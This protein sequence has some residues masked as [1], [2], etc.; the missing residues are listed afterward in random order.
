[1]DRR[2]PVGVLTL[3]IAI[4]CAGL[5]PA[6]ASAENISGTVTN[7][8]SV[9]IEG[10]CVF[11]QDANN[12]MS[13]Y[14]QTGTNASGQ[15]TV[16]VPGA[17]SYVIAFRT[18]TNGLCGTNAT[19]VVAE[20]WN[21]DVYFTDADPIAV[22]TGVN[23][24]GKDAQLASPGPV[25]GISGDVRN[26]QATPLEGVC[27][28]ALDN[29]QANAGFAITDAN[30]DYTIG[31]LPSGVPYKV[32]FTA[33]APCPAS[34]HT[35]LYFVEYYNNKA[36]FTSG[37]PVTVTV[38]GATPGIDAVLNREPVANDDSATVDEDS[39]A[40]DLSVTTND[41]DFDVGDAI[42]IQT[43][44]DSANGTTSLVQGTPD[45]IAYTPDPGYCSNTP[46]TFTYTVTGGD[47]ATV[48]V[49]VNCS[50]VAVDDA[51]S[52][53]ED[54]G[55]TTIAVRANDTDTDAGTKKVLSNTNGTNGTV[56][57]VNNGDDVT[58]TPNA[59]FCNNVTPDTFTYTLNG[60]DSATVS[61]TVTCV[62]DAPMAVTDAST[63]AEDASATTVSVLTNDTDVDG[64]PKTVAAK[65]SAPNGTVVITNGGN[66]LTYT[67]NANYC[68]SD[69][70]TYTLNGGSVGTVNVT[71]T[72]VDDVPTAVADSKTVAEDAGASTVDV[73]ANDTDIDAG[74]KTVGSKTDG[75]YGTVAITNSG[76]DVS[77]TPNGNYCGADSFTYTVNGGSSATVTVTVTCVDDSPA[78]ANDSKTVTEDAAATPID[79]LA[80]DTDA[81]GGPKS[82]ASASDPAHGTVAI[83]A[84]GLTYK[85]DANYCGP[86]SFT[87]ALNGSS[88]ATVAVTV[89]CVA[90]TPSDTTAPDTTIT[91]A[92]KAKLRI[93]KAK[94]KVKF[95]F[96]SNEAG[97]TF[98]CKL[99]RGAFKA[100]TSPRSFKLKPGKHTFTV[101]ATDAAGN[102]DPTPAK[103]KVKVVRL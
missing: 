91:K 69:I 63:V 82:I 93:R 2:L 71:V 3:V 78:A 1:M 13:L 34:P 40:N 26:S 51:T 28:A 94:V 21:N 44:N 7:L 66:D 90:D 19:P 32:I 52:V 73:L 87:Y 99:D 59:N 64:G 60:G 54:S 29:T 80:N 56:A 35:N 49:T 84:T 74:P 81:D 75:T 36:T 45:K 76:A 61:V 10:V 18:G 33:D 16:I 50:P 38:G 79:V 89:T 37:D 98:R 85:P 12:E 68:G 5:S 41:T 17:G 27:V 39:S 11:A 72:C 8:S 67:P 83:T 23:V 57:I 15:Y 48:S 95:L 96:T 14:G 43:V 25:G 97:S 4:A 42:E 62:D 30:G 101:V 100:C 24:T 86:D 70:F 92:P 20:Y 65:T 55:A 88:S 102:V 31:N 77:Y 6:I 58:Y 53:A 103:K 22:T 47:S 46:D 9:P